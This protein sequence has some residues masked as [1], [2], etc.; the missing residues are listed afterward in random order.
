M[1][2][3]NFIIILFLISACASLRDKKISEDS[4]SVYSRFNIYR[5]YWN[6]SEDSLNLFLY[7]DVPL[8]NFVFKKR[9]N[10]FYCDISYTLVI[11]NSIN[12]KQI[13]QYTVEWYNKRKSL[14][15]ATD[16]ASILESML[17]MSLEF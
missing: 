12:N 10:Y 3:N 7:I 4:S 9:S 2:T 1:K 17:L 16:C 15:T 6:V 8:T 5:Q 14:V 11:S 13:K